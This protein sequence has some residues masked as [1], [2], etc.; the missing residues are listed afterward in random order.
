M[1]SFGRP[2]NNELSDRSELSDAEQ[3][4]ASSFDRLSHEIF[5]VGRGQQALFALA[6][7]FTKTMLTCIPEPPSDA[8][9]LAIARGKERYTLLMKTAGRAM[10]GEARAAMLD[11]VDHGAEG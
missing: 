10:L 3:R 4:I 8:R 2:S 11:L 5:R 6:D 7:T 1:L 9:H